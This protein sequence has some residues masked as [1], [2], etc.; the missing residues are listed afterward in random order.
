MFNE[1]EIFTNI[2]QLTQQLELADGSTIQ[3]SG[4]GTV[5][6][7]LPHC[8]LELSN[9]LLVK[10][11]SYN[12]ISLGAIMK[13]N[14]KILTHDKKLFELIDH[15]NNIV[16][17]GTFNSGNFE[18]TTKQNQDLATITN[19]N[20]ILTLHQAAAHP[21]PEY[22]GKITPSNSGYK[23]FLRVVNGHSRYEKITNLASNNGSKF[24]NNQ[25]TTFFQDKAITHLTTAPYTPQQNPFSERGNRITITEA[26]CLLSDSGLDKSFWAKAVRTATHLENITPNKSLSYSTPYYKWFERPPT[27][28]HLQPFGCLCYYLNNK[29]QGKFSEKGSEGLFLGYEEG[30]RAYQI[31]DRQTGNVKIT[32]HARFV[33]NTFPKQINPEANRITDLPRLASDLEP[34]ITINTVCPKDDHPKSPT[35]NSLSPNLNTNVPKDKRG[36]HY[37]WIPKNQPPANEIHGE[38]GDPRNIIESRQQPKHSANAANTLNNK[39]PRSYQQAMTSELKQQWKNAI[40]NKLE[41]MEKHQ[42]WSP[43]TIDRKIK[44]LST[45]WVFK[46]KTNKN[47]DLTKFKAR[48]CIH[49]FHQKRRD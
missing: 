22:L 33:L 45:T 13:P 6:I 37:K 2:T 5:Q 34:H 40:S 16:I 17:N 3:A 26:R 39:N 18:L 47:G 35:N 21:S 31:L 15:N 46:R 28:Q 24:K 30:H 27:Y 49:G 7:K 12:L 38:V 23:Y 8:I 29:P 43:T 20:N 14:Y 44:P 10:N 19:H 36:D 42:V 32:H 41:N 9:C 25:L 4:S 1:P 48:L 11:L